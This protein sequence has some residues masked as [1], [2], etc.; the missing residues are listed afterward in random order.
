M[1]TVLLISQREKMLKF[2]AQNHST[3]IYQFFAKRLHLSFPFMVAIF[4]LAIPPSPVPLD[5][6]HHFPA[7]AGNGNFVYFFLLLPLLSAVN[8]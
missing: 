8:P 3:N 2:T 7:P 1:C 4:S 5:D 6:F